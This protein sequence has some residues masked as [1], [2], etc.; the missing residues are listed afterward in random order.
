[1]KITILSHNLTSNAAMRA[2]RLAVA[3]RHF[4]DVTMIGPVK[5]RGAWGALPQEPWIKPFES[6]NLPKFFNVLLEMILE[7]DADLLIAVKPYLAS[8]GLAL[9]AGECREVPVVLDI[10]DL[11]AALAPERELTPEQALADLRDPASILYLGV[12]VRAHQAAAVVTVASTNL[13][14]CFGG[15]L[16]PHGSLIEL[17]DLVNVDCAAA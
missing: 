13:Q 4:A 15:T 3:A 12:L 6:K 9:L 8:Y 10:D 17:F 1:M 5:D 14:R 2:H 7:A 16:V 11:D